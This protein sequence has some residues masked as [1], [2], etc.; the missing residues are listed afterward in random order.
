MIAGNVNDLRAL[1]CLAQHLLN[2]VVVR[3]RPEPV[4]LQRPAIDDIADQIDRVGIV[5]LEEVEKALRLRA[6]C[7]EVNIG[8]KQ[9]A[10]TAFLTTFTCQIIASHEPAGSRFQ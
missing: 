1:A 6:S 10:E 9:G 4:H 5:M 2:E 7:A 8:D 3:L